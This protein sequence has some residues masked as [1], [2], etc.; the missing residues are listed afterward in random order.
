M[1]M[2]FTSQHVE[3]YFIHD[4]MSMFPESGKRCYQ[5]SLLQVVLN[6]FE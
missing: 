2:M 5:Q 6:E 4:V 1:M 3:K